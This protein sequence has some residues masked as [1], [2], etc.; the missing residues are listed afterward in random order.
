MALRKP[1]TGNP[2]LAA[3]AARFARRKPNGRKGVE[4]FRSASKADSQKAVV[5][6]SSR[7]SPKTIV[8]WEKR[9]FSDGKEQG[10]S[11]QSNC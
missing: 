2:P 4:S 11:L 1:S 10:T 3:T 5:L 6:G 9:S 7:A 8:F